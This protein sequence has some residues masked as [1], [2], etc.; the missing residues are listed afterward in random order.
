M[1]IAALSS[2]DHLNASDSAY[3]DDRFLSAPQA[4]DY[5]LIFEDWMM[6]HEVYLF[7]I[8]YSFSSRFGNKIDDDLG[9][10]V[11]CNLIG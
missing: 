3:V 6:C 5:R 10:S 1:G 7:I 11:F 9:V 2:S 4:S 8:I